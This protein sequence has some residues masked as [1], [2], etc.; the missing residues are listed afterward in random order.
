MSPTIIVSIFNAGHNHC[1]LPFVSIFTSITIQFS[2]SYSFTP[3]LPNPT[4]TW[5]WVV[6]KKKELTQSFHFFVL[7]N[8][9]DKSICQSNL[10]VSGV[11]FQMGFGAGVAR[12]AIF[13]P[14]SD[15]TESIQCRSVCGQD[16]PV[17]RLTAGT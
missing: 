14:S 3:T 4:L 2:C 5:G 11:Q 13:P 1:C 12:R 15:C 8:K 6:G 16:S 9:H 7:P 10:A 17:S